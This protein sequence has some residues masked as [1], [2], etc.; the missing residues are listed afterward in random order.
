M[1]AGPITRRFPG[2]GLPWRSGVPAAGSQA[3]GSWEPLHTR[4]R[5]WQEKYQ[6]PEEQGLSIECP[7]HLCELNRE[8]VHA[9]YVN[10]TGPRA[11]QRKTH[12]PISTGGVDSTRRGKAPPLA[13][14]SPISHRGEIGPS[15][16]SPAGAQ[17]CAW[18]IGE[19]QAFCCSLSQERG[20]DKGLLQLQQAL[21]MGKG[22]LTACWTC[23]RCA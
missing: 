16:A 23:A 3:P 12:T 21:A 2:P 13:I 18:E 8:N 1:A 22:E 5:P 20:Q 19:G 17:I 11:E 14:L 10:S 15:G 7:R 9:I 6:L 4:V